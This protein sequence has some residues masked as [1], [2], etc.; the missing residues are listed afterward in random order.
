MEPSDTKKIKILFLFVVVL[1]GFM[2]FL[3]T[4]FYWATIERR[5]PRLEHSE[6]NHALRG[7]IV[8]A[9]GF[10]IATSQQLYKA[11]VDTRNIDPKKLDLFVR[12]YSLYSGDD[13]KA[14]AA[15]LG[16]NSGSTVLSY[17]IDSKTAKYLQELSR[18]L[19]KLGVFKSYEDPKTGVAFLHGLSVVESGEDRLYPAVDSLTPIVGYVRKVE[20]KNITKTTGVKGIERYY[21]DKL[22]SVQDSLVYGFRDIANTVILDGNSVSSRRF[23][24]Y[25]VHLTISLKM[26]KIIESVLDQYQKNLEAKEIIVGILNSDTAEFVA[27]ASSNRFNPDL[28]EKKDYGS[29]NV[30]AIEY[31]YEP[32]SVLKSITFALLLK[33]NKVNPYD[34]VNVYG[35][36]YKLGTKVIKDTHKADKLTAEDIIVYSSNVGTAQI[37]QKLDAM[38]FYQGLKDFGFSVR[39]GVDLPFENPGIIPTINRFNSPIY[40]ATV[41][42]G[43]GMN[44]TFMQVIRAYNVFNNNGRILTPMLVKKLVSPIGQELFPE[45]SPENQIIPVSVAKRMQKILIKVVQQG[46]GTGAKIEGLE[47]GGKT[48]TAHIAEDGEYVRSYN[49]SFFGFANDKKNRYTIGV[50]VREAKKRQAYFAAQSA[51]PVFKE[52]VEKLVEN[53]YLTPSSDL[54]PSN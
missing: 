45:K 5:L 33:A 32:G 13:P 43:Y 39:S 20:Q 10:K 6:V 44:A 30:S 24:G 52:V 49:G 19:Y 40:K 28:I 31:I 38:E 46:T 11:I 34:I 36:S 42:Y 12:L 17:R 41:G 27:L 26:Q 51:V 29:L 37:A 16:S 15:T 14:V 47:I 23:D 18:K 50:L 8:S 25:D 21:E 2:I 22:S 54:V 1:L 48:G 4:L 7:N 3:G 53:G 35:G 9:D